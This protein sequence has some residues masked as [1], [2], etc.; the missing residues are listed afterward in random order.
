MA[1]LVDLG[2]SPYFA[3]D[4]SEDSEYYKVLFKPAYALQSRELI[5][6]QNIVQ[7]QIARYGNFAFRDGDM[8]LPGYISSDLKLAYVK[9][10][11]QHNR[12]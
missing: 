7:K 12:C 2:V 11:T 3:T 5:E 10:E 9:L 6:V 8:V 1:E 4:T